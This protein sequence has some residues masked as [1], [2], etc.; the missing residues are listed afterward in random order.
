MFEKR[1]MM[2][3]KKWDKKLIKKIILL[4]IN[5]EGIGEDEIIVF[6]LNGGDGI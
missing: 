5:N 3:L 2:N 6:F 1:F 4:W